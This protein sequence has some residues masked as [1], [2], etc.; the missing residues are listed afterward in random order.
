MPISPYLRDQAFDPETIKV[1]GEA[2]TL[3]CEALGLTERTDRMTELVAQRIIEMA[4]RGV[5]TKTEL[6]RGTLRDLKS[7]VG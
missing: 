1:M 5:R 6:Y 7:K 4:Q 2:F 3:V